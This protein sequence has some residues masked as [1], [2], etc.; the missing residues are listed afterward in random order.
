MSCEGKC[1]GVE[2]WDVTVGACPA[3]A[4]F[5]TLGWAKGGGGKDSAF[6]AGRI[7]LTDSKLPGVVLFEDPLIFVAEVFSETLFNL[8]WFETF[9]EW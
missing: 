2:D 4:V 1:G 9:M 8:R 6:G 3:W 5:G 7:A